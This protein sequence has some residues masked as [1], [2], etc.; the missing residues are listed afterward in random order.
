M[1]SRMWYVVNG[2]VKVCVDVGLNREGSNTFS[3][4][5]APCSF[6]SVT[7]FSP[8]FSCLTIAIVSAEIANR[9]R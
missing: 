2:H 5:L 1:V 4:I 3:P 6:G 7:T 8:L 9:L